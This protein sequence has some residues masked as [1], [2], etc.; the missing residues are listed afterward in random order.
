MRQMIHILDIHIQDVFL[1]FWPPI[2]LCA[3][4]GYIAAGKERKLPG[5]IIGLVGGVV[6]AIVLVILRGNAPPTLRS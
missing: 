2:I 6:L 1:F 4:I 3:V 5:A